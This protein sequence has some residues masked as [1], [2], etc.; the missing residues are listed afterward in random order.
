MCVLTCRLEP[1]SSRLATVLAGRL[2]NNASVENLELESLSSVFACESLF[3]EKDL[4]Q[5][6][7]CT[8]SP[9]YVPVVALIMDINLADVM[10]SVE[11]QSVPYA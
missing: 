10:N 5:C 3:F 4:L 6:K 7:D 2:F 8:P 9:L 11:L 1:C